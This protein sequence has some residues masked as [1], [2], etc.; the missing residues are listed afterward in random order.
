MRNSGSQNKVLKNND[1]DDES[2]SSVFEGQSNS[3]LRNVKP[4]FKKKQT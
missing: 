2:S 4:S 1:F 3:D